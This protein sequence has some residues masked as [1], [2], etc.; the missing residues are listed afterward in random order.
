ML[1]PAS[2]RRP[3]GGGTSP[4]TEFPALPGIHCGVQSPILPKVIQFQCQRQLP[5][6]VCSCQSHIA[7]SLLFC[8]GLSKVDVADTGGW[9]GI[10]WPR[11]KYSQNGGNKKV[12][13]FNRSFSRYTLR[14]VIKSV[15]KQTN[16]QKTPSHCRIMQEK[17]PVSYYPNF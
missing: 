17:K 12:L 9:E 7:I 4:R 1:G 2:F 5:M 16:K 15:Y 14:M 8:T 13:F 10:R 6:Q 3:E 11:L